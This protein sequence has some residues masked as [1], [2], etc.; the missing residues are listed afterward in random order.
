MAIHQAIQR[1]FPV[2]CSQI[3]PNSAASTSMTVTT[4]KTGPVAPSMML[5]SL[6]RVTTAGPK[7]PASA[8]PSMDPMPSHSR[9]LAGG[10][11]CAQPNQTS[12]ISPNH[13]TVKA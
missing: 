5:P 13:A 9:A 1:P 6:H 10:S 4:A 12:V 2:R 7:N 11:S 8:I 3:D